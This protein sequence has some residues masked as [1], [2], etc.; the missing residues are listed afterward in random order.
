MGMLG[1][2]ADAD[3][4]SA[5]TVIAEAGPVAVIVHNALAL[6]RT[7]ADEAERLLQLATP[8]ARARVAA[9]LAG[10]VKEER[11]PVFQEGARDVQAR[12]ELC[13]F[14]ACAAHLQRRFGALLVV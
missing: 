12:L 5:T 2:A 10:V 14:A 6:S 1:V 9:V 13:E 8:E 11:A 4:H 3:S 7:A